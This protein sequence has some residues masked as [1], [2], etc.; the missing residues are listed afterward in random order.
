MTRIS[1]VSD[2]NFNREYNCF[3]QSLKEITGHEIKGRHH[4]QSRTKSHSMLY[5]INT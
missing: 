1:K 2:S 3:T 5:K 4:S